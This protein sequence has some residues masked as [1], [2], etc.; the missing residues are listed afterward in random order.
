[1]IPSFVNDKANR[2]VRNDYYG[3]A[4]YSPKNSVQLPAGYH[5]TAIRICTD[6]EEPGGDV[7][8]VKIWGAKLDSLGRPVQP[9]GPVK[10]EQNKCKDWKRKVSCPSG[11]IA[12]SIDIYSPHHD[13]LKLR[14]AKLEPDVGSLFPVNGEVQPSNFMSGSGTLALDVKVTNDSHTTATVNLVSAKLIK[15]GE[16]LCN[17]KQSGLTKSLP[18]GYS[19]TQRVSM[20]CDWAKIRNSGGCKLGA[21]CNARFE[22]KVRATVQGNAENHDYAN[23]AVITKR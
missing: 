8:G 12:H 21:T 13:A 7:K 16:V 3:Y 11:M 9:M 23:R 2:S 1:V 14:C 15:G 19:Y 20:S 17:G 5:M 18:T 4:T 6:D 10:Y 22:G